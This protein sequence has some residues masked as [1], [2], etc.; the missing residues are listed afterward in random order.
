MYRLL[1]LI[2]AATQPDAFLSAF[3]C[4]RYGPL[5]AFCLHAGNHPLLKRHICVRKTDLDHIAAMSAA[6]SVPDLPYKIK[7]AVFWGG[8][9]ISTA[10]SCM[11]FN[12]LRSVVRRSTACILSI[13]SSVNLCMPILP[14]SFFHFMRCLPVQIP[15]IS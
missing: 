10:T 12:L 3:I 2:P 13:S 14:F 7:D 8:S 1:V 4:K 6:V 11:S 15:D 9:P 5:S